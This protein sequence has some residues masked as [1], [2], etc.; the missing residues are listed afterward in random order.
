V[1]PVESQELFQVVFDF[2]TVLVHTTL[3]LDSPSQSGSDKTEDRKMYSNFQKKIRKEIA[4]KLTAGVEHLKMLLPLAKKN[5]DIIAVEPIGTVKD[6]KGNKSVPPVSFESGDR[7][8]G[9][10]VILLFTQKP[11]KFSQAFHILN[12]SQ[13][14]Q[15]NFFII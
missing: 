4:D 3:A 12:S 13:I 7:K 1:E 8:H 10:Q 15:I 9:L 11:T 6:A 5:L 14:L 2:L